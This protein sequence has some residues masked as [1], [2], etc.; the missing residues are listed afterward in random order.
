MY[1]K[2]YTT[3]MHT[4]LCVGLRLT[5]KRIIMGSSFSSFAKPLVFCIWEKLGIIPKC[6]KLDIS[7]SY[8]LDLKC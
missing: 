6:W 3:E 5:L 1:F 4:V 2:T 7:H 8:C